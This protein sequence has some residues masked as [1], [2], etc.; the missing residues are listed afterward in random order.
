M[1]ITIWERQF[2]H[3]GY[4]ILFLSFLKPSYFGEIPFWDRFFNAMRIATFLILFVKRIIFDKELSVLVLCTLI[5]TAI[6]VLMTVINS[7]DYAQ[8]FIFMGMLVGSV[9]LVETCGKK[10]IVGLINIFSFLYELLIY[11]NLI[12]IILFPNGLYRYTTSIGW[13]SNQVWLFGLRNGHPSWLLCGLFFCGLHANVCQNKFTGILRYIC[14]YAAAIYTVILL[15]SGTGYVMIT[16]YTLLMLVFIGYGKFRFHANLAVFSQVVLF[17]AIT[18]FSAT[19]LFENFFMLFGKDGTATGRI[20]VW[21][22]TWLRILDKPIFGHGIMNSNDLWWLQRIAAGATT[23]HNTMLDIIFRGGIVGLVAY[24]VYLCIVAKRLDICKNSIRLYNFATIS[25]FC[26]LLI[27]QSEGGAGSSNLFIMTS[28]IYYL[29][30][31]QQVSVSFI[32]QKK[33]NHVRSFQ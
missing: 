16:V 27:F 10:D 13:T 9:M 26:M 25:I 7:G 11:V 15:K 24:L 2:W 6:P 31:M 23:A 14:L 1:R 3:M 32:R 18:A 21:R 28:V 29:S 8:G 4:F 17:I 5:Y 33:K 30:Y 22:T 12:T 19:M 20:L